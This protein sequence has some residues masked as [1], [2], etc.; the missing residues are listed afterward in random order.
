M[1]YS[2]SELVWIFLTVSFL[3]WI[4]ETVYAAVKQK[5][6]VNRGLVNGPLCI[7][8][9]IVSIMNAVFLQELSIWWVFIGSMILATVIEWSA[10]HIL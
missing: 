9:G 6:F 2:V 4:L 8:Y 10:G 5:Q 1:K 7:I 3:G